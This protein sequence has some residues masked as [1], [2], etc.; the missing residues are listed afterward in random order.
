MIAFSG[1]SSFI[2]ILSTQDQQ[3]CTY[4]EEKLNIYAELGELSGFE[5]V[6]LEPHLLIKPDPGE[7]PQA[8]SLL[9]A[10]LKEGKMLPKG[11]DSTSS[12]NVY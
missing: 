3:I 9:A 10:A 7:P 6:H 4:L 1:K 12:E 11:F 8:A 2:E 5:D